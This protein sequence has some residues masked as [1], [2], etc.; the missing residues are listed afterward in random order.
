MFAYDVDGDGDN[1]VI[2]ALNAHGYGLAW[3][4]NVKDTGGTKI[5]FK[6]HLILSPK[7]EEKLN[8]VQFSQLHAVDLID[9]DGDGLKD[10]LTGKR[11]WAHGPHGDPDPTARPT[12][13]GS[14]SSATAATRGQV[15]LRAAPDRRL[16][17]R[18]HPDH[19]RRRQR[20]RHPRRHRRQQARDDPVPVEEVNRPPARWRGLAT[21]VS[22][23]QPHDDGLDR[24]DGCRE[25]W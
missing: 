16:L 20:R 19:R 9:I 3:Y 6:Q 5:T 15:E 2:T 10:I 23:L 11:Y 22:E 4:E 13:T 7:P 18:R 1:D 24:E 8:D 17:R 25:R 14:S 21:A 12:S